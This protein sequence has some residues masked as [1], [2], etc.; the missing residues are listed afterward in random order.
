M[1]PE[2]FCQ[3]PGLFRIEATGLADLLAATFQERRMQATAE[4]LL[5]LSN[6]KALA[7]SKEHYPQKS[8]TPWR[9]PASGWKTTA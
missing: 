5:L 8:R 3:L 9:P 2:L 7:S 4:A 6:E 1:K